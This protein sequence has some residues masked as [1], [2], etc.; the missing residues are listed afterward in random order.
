MPESILGDDRILDTPEA[1]AY[2]KLSPS[3]LEKLRVSGCGPA[4]LKPR[5][6]VVYRLSDIDN[7]LNSSRRGS[8][9]HI[10]GQREHAARQT[11]RCRR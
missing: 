8:T 2:C 10:E 5:R 4:F 7:W 9:S 11:P 3:T 6:R 1:A